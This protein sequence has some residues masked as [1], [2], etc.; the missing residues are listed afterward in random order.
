MR[1]AIRASTVGLAMRPCTIISDND[2]SGKIRCP[3]NAQV[4]GL[5]YLYDVEDRAPNNLRA[6]R[7]FNRMTQQELA[8][9]LGTA[10]SVI[11]DLERGVVQLNDKWLR[12]LAP[13]LK[14]QPGH[15]LDYDPAELDSDIIDIWAHIPEDSRSQA[16][17]VLRTFDRRTGT[18]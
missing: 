9:A 2:A 10:K 16:A 8:D 18:Q 6:W 17:A 13:V 3:L 4:R 14:T 5:S 15:I 7:K 11:S 12:R 1:A